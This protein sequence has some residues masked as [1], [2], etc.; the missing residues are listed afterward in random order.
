MKFKSR[1]AATRLAD[2]VAVPIQTMRNYF[3]S[4]PDKWQPLQQRILTGQLLVVMLLNNAWEEVVY[5]R[6]ILGYASDCFQTVALS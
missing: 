1:S 4:S 3:E 2:D 6:I 5:G